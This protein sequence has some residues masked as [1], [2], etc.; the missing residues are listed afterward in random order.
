MA[1]YRKIPFIATI[2]D[3]GPLTKA[4]VNSEPGKHLLAYREEMSFSEFAETWGRTLGVKARYELSGPDSHWADLPKELR[5]DIE[6]A[7][8]Y[9]SEIGYDGGDPSIIRPSEVS[10]VD[11]FTFT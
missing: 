5:L 2:E 6:D 7:A 8:V 3:T 11:R 9:I 10:S 4:L 1:P